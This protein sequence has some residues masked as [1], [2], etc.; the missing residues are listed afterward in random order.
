MAQEGERNFFYYG[1]RDYI[2]MIHVL[3]IKRKHWI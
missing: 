1:A 2:T 3:A